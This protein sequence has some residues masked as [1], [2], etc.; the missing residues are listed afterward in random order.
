MAHSS[1]LALLFKCV[2]HVLLGCAVALAGDK[3]AVGKM[4]PHGEG[5]VRHVVRIGRL[6]RRSLGS[7]GLYRVGGCGRVR[8]CMA[9][10]NTWIAIVDVAD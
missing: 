3:P 2:Y 4:S 7:D 10:H 5:G 6:L 8:I 9:Q 1:A